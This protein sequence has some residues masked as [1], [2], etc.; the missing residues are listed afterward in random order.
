MAALVNAADILIEASRPR[1]VAR[2]ALDAEAAVAGGT[3]WSRSPRPS[4]SGSVTT[5]TYASPCRT[6]HRR[7]IPETSEALRSLDAEAVRC[8]LIARRIV[9]ARW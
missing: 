8:T 4:A 1:A 2:F 9:E 3:F 6:T 5:Q 7:S